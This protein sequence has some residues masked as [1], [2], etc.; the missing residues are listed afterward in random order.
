[1]HGLAEMDKL[2]FAIGGH[3][4]HVR[5]RSVE[6]YDPACNYWVLVS[7][8]IV[9]RSVAGV[10]SLWGSIYVVGGYDGK[11]YLDSVEYYDIKLEQWF[12]GPSMTCRRSALGLVTYR[13]S[14]Y[15]CGGLMEVLSALLN[16]LYLAMK[17]GTQLSAC[18]LS[19]CTLE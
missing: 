12:V 6:F 5:L 14:L 13:G 2:L 17:H 11:E 1:M 3:D 10:A 18:R 4:G 15:A 8:M 9:P 7:P 19:V 16:V